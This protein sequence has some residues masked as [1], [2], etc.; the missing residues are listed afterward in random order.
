MQDSSYKSSSREN[1]IGSS[2]FGDVESVRSDDL[3][4]IISRQVTGDWAGK[5]GL[6]IS[7]D[8]VMER[9]PYLMTG[10][11]HLPHT[12]SAPSTTTLTA[13][14]VFGHRTPRRKS[15]SEGIKA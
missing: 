4:V 14:P 3:P 11:P 6:G 10:Y 8:I 5:S 7:E 9:K 15:S 1:S 12:E 13:A 2:L